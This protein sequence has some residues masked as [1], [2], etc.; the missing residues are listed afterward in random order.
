[1]SSK[2]HVVIL[3]L[4]IVAQ[5]APTPVC[6]A[7]GLAAIVVSDNIADRAAADVLSAF[8]E[9]FYFNVDVITIEWGK[10]PSDALALL[11]SYSLIYVVGGP[12]AVPPEVELTVGNKSV[13]RLYGEDRVETSLA[14]LKEILRIAPLPVSSV[15][16]ADGYSEPSVEAGRALSKTTLLPLV[17]ASS[18][19]LQKVVSELR[20]M[21]ITAVI[22]ANSTKLARS[23]SSLQ[24]KL[25]EPEALPG[26]IE[27]KLASMEN[28]T[29]ANQSLLE[30]ELRK[31]YLLRGEAYLEAGM[32]GEAMLSAL[33]AELS[34]PALP[35]I[36]SCQLAPRYWSLLREDSLLA[37]VVGVKSNL[38][39][40]STLSKYA[41]APVSE[42]AALAS[43]LLSTALEFLGSGRKAEAAQLV[44][45]ARELSEYILAEAV[46]GIEGNANVTKALR[47]RL[48]YVKAQALIAKGEELHPSLAL[49][50]VLV[51]KAEAALLSGDIIASILLAEEAERLLEYQSTWVTR[52]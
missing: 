20:E 43:S 15:V 52:G 18:V 9:R 28:M 41:G 27:K 26:I 17:L 44:S 42:A 8:V 31:C 19:K 35:V 25:L 24:L 40:A 50:A 36:N 14:V 23:M 4:A 12:L 39:L 38:Y 3:V 1:M 32:L 45:S 16:L 29:L 30:R 47:A 2:F 37:Q 22:V 51:G 33:A 13:I 10:I 34:A 46:E 11:T 21:N 6:R 7:E 49:P 5:L 48:A